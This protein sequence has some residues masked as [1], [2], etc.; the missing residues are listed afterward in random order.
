MC[1]HA[2]QRQDYTGINFTILGM[3]QEK[4]VLLGKRFL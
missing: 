4:I 1:G 2:F 3:A